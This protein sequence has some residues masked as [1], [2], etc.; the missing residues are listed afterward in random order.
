MNRHA[1][2]VLVID[3]DLGFVWWLGEIFHAAGCKVMP[4]LSCREALSLAEAANLTVD[5]IVVNPAL[6]GVSGMIKTLRRTRSAKIVAIQ[7]RTLLGGS[8][9]DTHAVLE[10]PSQGE[11]ISRA[12]WLRTVRGILAQIGARAAS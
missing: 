7:H 4:A 8:R 3:Q 1:P 10:R 5:L 9:L 6:T 12:E 2:T 11:P